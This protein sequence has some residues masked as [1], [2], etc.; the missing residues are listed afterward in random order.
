[1]STVLGH[2]ESSGVY[3]R[4]SHIPGHWNGYSSVLVTS[5]IPCVIDGDF[6]YDAV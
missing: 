6:V 4:E 3:T 5:E 1:M 2:K